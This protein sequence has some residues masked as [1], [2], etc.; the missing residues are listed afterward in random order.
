MLPKEKF[1]NIINEAI[2]KQLSD[3]TYLFLTDRR[4]IYNDKI[5]KDKFNDLIKHGYSMVDD[6][7]VMLN[8]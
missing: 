5:L 1:Y 4:V 6:N 3:L 7:E 2:S 8:I